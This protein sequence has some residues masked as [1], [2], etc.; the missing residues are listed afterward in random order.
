VNDIE[1]VVPIS[2]QRWNSDFLPTGFNLT[3]KT[4]CISFQNF[5]A[6]FSQ[7]IFFFIRVVTTLMP[8]FRRK[9]FPPFRG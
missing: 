2:L 7:I 9:S 5:T 4:T 8:A 3:S 1:V 6:D